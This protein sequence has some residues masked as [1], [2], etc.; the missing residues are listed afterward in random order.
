MNTTFAREHNQV[1]GKI[2]RSF[3]NREAPTRISDE[4]F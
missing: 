4:S 2:R 1:F 3:G